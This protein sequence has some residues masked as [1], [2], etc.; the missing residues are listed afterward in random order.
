[1]EVGRAADRL[2]A[3]LVDGT[4]RAVAW[5]TLAMVLITVAVV[6][7]RYGFDLGWIAV[8][9]SV[10]YLHA[11]VFMLAAAW[12]LSEDAHV[13]V[14]I[15][16]RARGPRYRAGVDLAGSLLF[17]VP[18]CL[19]WCVVA[20]D[21]VASSWSLLEGSREPGGLPFVYLLKTLILAAPALLLI[22][23]LRLAAKSWRVLRRPE[24]QGDDAGTA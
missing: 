22:Q 24:P 7:L 4:G 18:F 14:D 5:L 20:W 12:T 8:Q 9:E 10:T 13:R 19:Y 6:V 23:A 1:M 15:V 3:V 2:A 11:L 21:Y 16:Y 17:L